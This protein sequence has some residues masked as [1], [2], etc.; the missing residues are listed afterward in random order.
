MLKHGG[1]NID[2]LSLLHVWIIKLKIYC[3]RN[4]W[5]WPL[6]LGFLSLVKIF[7]TKAKKVI[8]CGSTVVLISGC[9]SCN[10]LCP[11]SLN[12]CT[13][14]MY[15]IILCYI[16]KCSCIYSSVPLANIFPIYFSWNKVDEIVGTFPDVVTS[17]STFMILGSVAFLPFWV[18]GEW[19][20]YWIPE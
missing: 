15:F 16:I 18:M 9:S 10:L 12:C 3:L 11:H 17:T 20:V 8:I 19:N 6:D 1:S 2:S 13:Y 7:S 14:N 5:W 4:I